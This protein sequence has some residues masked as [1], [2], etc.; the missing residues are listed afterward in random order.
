[1]GRTNNLVESVCL[2]NMLKENNFKA[3]VDNNKIIGF[4]KISTSLTFIPINDV[5]LTQVFDDMEDIESVY[6]FGYEITHSADDN[7]KIEYEEDCD[8]QVIECVGK[9]NLHRFLDMLFAHF[10][11]EYHTFGAHE[12]NSHQYVSYYRQ[13]LNECL[14]EYVEN[15]GS[16]FA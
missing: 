12:C 1:M 8:T 7:W 3:I 15:S 11:L 13:K 16:I 2:V 10:Q 9:Y 5:I 6:L 14:D 4:Y